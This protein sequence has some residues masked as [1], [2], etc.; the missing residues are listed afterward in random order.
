MTTFLIL[1]YLKNSTFKNSKD[2][3]YQCKLCL[4]A[5][6][7]SYVEIF[8]KAIILFLIS[9]ISSQANDDMSHPHNPYTLKKHIQSYEFP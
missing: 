2:F 3:E 9:L 8:M 4:N 7:S 5:A 1:N 6:W